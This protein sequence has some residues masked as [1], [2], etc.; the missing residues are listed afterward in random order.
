MLTHL[1][2]AT[3]ALHERAEAAMPTLD[4][5]S[6]PDLYARCVADLHGFYAAWEP[7]IWNTPGVDDVVTDGDARRKLPLLA[8]DLGALGQPALSASPEL[9]GRTVLPTCGHALG[10]LYVLE[11]ATLG[12]RVILRHIAPPLGL[13]LDGG[14][15]FFHGY[16]SR[17]GQMWSSFGRALE[18]WAA[19][20]G[21]VDAAVAGATSCFSSFESWLRSRALVSATVANQ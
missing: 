20:G 17:T 2:A 8:R 12:G 9:D 3:A 19:A 11:G 14:L 13:P 16:G 1:K 5:L 18:Q 4:E 15:S 21:D 6:C 10:A 7:A